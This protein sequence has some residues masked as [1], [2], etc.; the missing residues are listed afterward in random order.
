MQA[1]KDGAFG[2]LGGA[3]LREFCGWEGEHHGEAATWRGCWDEGTAHGFDEASGEGEAKT[4][5]RVVVPV[6]E[7]LKRQEDLVALVFGDAWSVVD[8]AQL[9]SGVLFTGTDLPGAGLVG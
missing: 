7:A 3:G 9:D 8:D 6:A 5:T 2:G 1:A 4:H